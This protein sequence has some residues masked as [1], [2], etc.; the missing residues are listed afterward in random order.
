MS[1]GIRPGVHYVLGVSVLAIGA[2]GMQWAKQRNTLMVLKR[3]LP[4][5]RPLNDFRRSAL[6]PYEHDRSNK[7]SPDIVSELGT[8]KYIDWNI[9]DPSGG[10]LSAGINL[11]VTYYTG[12]Q[13][14]VPHVPE[15]C[16]RQGAFAGVGDE[17]LEFRFDRLGRSVPVRRLSFYPPREFVKKTYVY[18]TIR[19]NSEFYSDRQRVRFALKD[20]F[21]THLYYSKVEVAFPN[22]ADPDLSALDE[23]AR[24]LLQKVVIELEDAHW[25]EKG[26]ERDTDD[27]ES[28]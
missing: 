9:K 2:A 22:V 23:K 8:E 15:E 5:R 11:S 16:Y 25:P 21:D 20:P 24:E 6:H 1:Q 18:Y 28:L 14:Q 13:D 10:R 12:V 27:R 19:V 3:P 4:L 17:K 26:A 7:L